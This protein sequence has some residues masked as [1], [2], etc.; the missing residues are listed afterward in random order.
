[1]KRYLQLILATVMVFSL[2]AGPVFGEV[3]IY[4]TPEEYTAQ[5]GAEIL[6]YDEAPR[7]RE[8]VGQGLLPPVEERIPKQPLVL[9]PRDS[10]GRYGG[11]INTGCIA[12]MENLTDASTLRMENLTGIAPG[13]S[14]ELFP[15][16]I[17][18]WS[19]SEDYTELTFYLREGMKWSDGVDFTADDF[20]YWYEDVL[21]NEELTPVIP[22]AWKPGGEVMGMEKID[23]YTIHFTF[24]K[25][26]PAITSWM[27][28][29]LGLHPYL[30]RHYLEQYHIKHNPRA[31]ELAQEQ[32]YP[33]WSDLHKTKEERGDRLTDPKRPTLLPWVLSEIDGQGNKYY[34]R[35]PYF[36]KVDTEGNQ[37]PY[38]DEVSRMLVE[39]MEVWTLRAIAGNWD[40]AGRYESLHNYA[41]FLE[42]QE[43]AGYRVILADW[44]QDANP[45][46]LLNQTVEDPVKRELFQN[47]KFKQAL[48]IAI[49]REEINDLIYYGLAVP[50]Q[51]SGHPIFSF[52][53]DW[54]G[55]Y[56]AEYDPE[57]ANQL[58]DELG[59]DQRDAAGY[60]LMR[61]GR[62]LRISLE[63]G[64]WGMYPDVG[65]LVATYWEEVGVDVNFN[66]ISGPLATEKVLANT[67][68][69]QLQGLSR[70]EHRHHGAPDT[71][72]PTWGGRSSVPW[73]Q[74][75]D[76]DGKE[77]EEPPE[78]VKR[79]CALIEQWQQVPM[80]SEEYLELGREILTVNVKG[81]YVIGIVGLNPE[82]VI[83]N[84]NLMNTPTE[85][86]T[87]MS[88]CGGFHRLYQ[89]SQFYY[90]K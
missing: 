78:E 44:L 18:G 34:E 54:M 12:P 4:P 1:M 67:Q 85:D 59:L 82:P 58:L 74:W 45:G 73:R 47:E 51:R 50:R 10:I 6:K 14:Q 23:K 48:S 15:N 25:P 75:F 7:L 77:G 68:E 79:L 30:P 8:K 2:L 46:V 37:L 21:L 36:W 63:T 83:Y 61:D 43:R 69:A 31:N 22:V 64:P 81:L 20:M 57:R 35:N 13:E 11:T 41:L 53:E 86:G 72:Y 27:A 24:A 62:T 70:G 71:W 52:Y 19:F 29:D 9:Q 56:Y 42:N 89:P 5:T 76:T 17:K 28:V 66:V 65:E 38:V 84:Q 90:V 3:R 55:K 39:D 26:Y 32:G 49:D 16:I 87:Y 40:A 88:F 33:S 80:G 60:R